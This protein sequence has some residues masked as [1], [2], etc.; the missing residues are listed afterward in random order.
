[1]TASSSPTNTAHSQLDSRRQQ[2]LAA[3]V[4]LLYNNANVGIVVTLIATVI[5]GRLQ[6]EVAPHLIILG[7]CLYM[8]LVSVGRFILG[9]R[10]GR[11]AQSSLETNT[12]GTAFA[13]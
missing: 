2:I 3:Q 10:Y 9:R 11:T 13:I 4:R 7:W 12:W 1:M 8:F 6:W 5:L